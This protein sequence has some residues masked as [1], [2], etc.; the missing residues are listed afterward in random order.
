MK[1]NS[2]NKTN[3]EN[4]FVQI[5]TYA[6]AFGMIINCNSIFSTGLFAS[7]LN[8]SLLLLSFLEV[9]LI[10][11][12]QKIKTIDWGKYLVSILALSAYLV[13]Y[14]LLQ[15]KISTPL[16]SIKM[17]FTFLIFFS[18]AYL[19]YKT[20]NSPLLLDAYVNLITVISIISLFF[21]I[22]GSNLHLIRPNGLYLTK[23]AQPTFQSVSSYYGLY[24]ET[25]TMGS[26]WRNSAIFAEA[27][28][29]SLN[30][31]LALAILILLLKKNRYYRWKI[32]ILT[33]GVVST[34]SSTGYI[35]LVLL[36]LGKILIGDDRNKYVF[37]LKKIIT[38][39]ILLLGVILINYFFSQKMMS[40]SGVSRGQDYIN[41]FRA[42]E[43][44][45]LLGVGLNMANSLS[46]EDRLFI[47]KFGY[48]NS[49]GKILGE[50][51][52]YVTILY[53]ISMIRSIYIGIKTQQSDRIFFTVILGYLF[54]TTIFVNT[55]LMFFIFSLIAVWT[56]KGAS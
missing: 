56:P 8:N 14:I 18:L 22:F 44:Y 24:F 20:D 16:T 30:F 45:P 9:F 41:S 38:P 3:K 33:L 2:V 27:P 28:M 29:A 4:V 12:L 48:S 46:P 35:F 32:L 1:E 39:I 7:R 50:T 21:W 6:L 40:N 55:F 53:I 51:G 34:L 23:W 13:I 36:I 52:I 47:G 49:F 5:I 19:V 26:M 10:V 15:Q 25:Q 54:V 11:I 42:W 17:L 31:S 43:R 37:I